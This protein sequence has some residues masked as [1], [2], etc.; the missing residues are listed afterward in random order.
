MGK[1]YDNIQLRSQQ[2]SAE[3]D[4]IEA[5]NEAKVADN[6]PVVATLAESTPSATGASVKTAIE[7]AKNTAK[8]EDAY[9]DESDTVKLIV[10]HLENYV[11]N[12][13][14]SKV[15]TPSSMIDLQKMLVRTLEQL[16]NLPSNADFAICFK[17]LM[18]L[19][20]KYEHGA[21]APNMRLRRI[22]SLNKGDAYL[23]AYIAFLDMICA[24][25]EPGNRRTLIQRYNV[26]KHS[27]FA[28]P[29][30]RERLVQFIREIAG[31]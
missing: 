17:R 3:A 4:R 24:F 12:A 16:V 2:L 29:E 28:K 15:Q 10:S 6:A 18:A 27:L 23:N 19:V 20:K 8:A 1:K 9:R 21:F 7:P 11:R 31:V 13:D 5:E 14:P 30:Y 26:A 22:S 25:A